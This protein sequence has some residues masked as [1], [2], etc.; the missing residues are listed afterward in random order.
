MHLNADFNLP[1][2]LHADELDWVS[3][4]MAGVQRKMLDRIGNEKARATSLVQYAPGSHFNTHV[5]TGGEEFLVLQGVFQDEHGDYPSGSY[6]R[7]PPQ[8]SHT[9]GS[10][11]GCIIFVK[12]W[13][14]QPDDRQAVSIHVEQLDWQI[15][16]NRPGVLIKSLFRNA[17]EHVQ[18]ERWPAS[19]ILDV[20]II[21]GMELLV[22]KGEL[23]YGDNPLRAWSWLRLPQGTT[24]LQLITGGQPCEL[25]V[26]YGQQLVTDP[27]RYTSLNQT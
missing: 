9:P 16:L 12:L 10:E 19:S 15:D 6:L 27:G 22:L 24:K 25:W 17:H 11:P 21:D 14:F 23:Q 3:S 8:S 5:H 4:P 26:K 20:T 1:A 2:L 18:L 13:Q 7:N